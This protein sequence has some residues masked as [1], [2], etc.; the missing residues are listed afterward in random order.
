MKQKTN[1][2]ADK[3]KIAI[4]SLCKFMKQHRLITIPFLQAMATQKV[5]T[6][7]PYSHRRVKYRRVH[8]GKKWCACCMNIGTVT[9]HIIQV[10]NG[11][12]ACNNNLIPLCNDCHKKVHPWIK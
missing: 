4:L 8:D 7:M 11:G 12:G 3:Q 2:K 9:H 6:K 1:P 5:Y 10:K